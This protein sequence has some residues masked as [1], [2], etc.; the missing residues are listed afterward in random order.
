MGCHSKVDDQGSDGMQHHRCMR[1]SPLPA[2]L[3]HC[4]L[5]QCIGV[6]LLLMLQPQLLRRLGLHGKHHL[7][8]RL[9]QGGV[10]LV[11]V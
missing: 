6:L 7:L 9:L 10:W 11:R 8:L 4:H 2:Q 3:L 1:P 5:L